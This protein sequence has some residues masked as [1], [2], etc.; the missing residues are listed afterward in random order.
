MLKRFFRK[1]ETRAYDQYWSQF[2][3]IRSGTAVT[4]DSAQS[5]SACYSAV[6]VIS[7]AIGALPLHLYKR[8]GDDQTKA[9]GH[10]LYG[11][12]HHEPNDQQSACEFREWL[13]AS[14]LLTGNGYAR[15]ER[16]HDGQVRSLSPL[17][18]DRVNVVIKAGRIAGYEFH[19]DDGVQHKLLPDEVFHLRHRAGDNPLIGV[20]PITASRQTFEVA[21]AEREHGHSSFANGTRLSGVLKYPQVLKQEQRDALKASWN[22]QY[23]GG[24]NAGRVALLEAGV[25]FQ[26]LSMSLADAD[27]VAIRKFSVEEV[28]R[29]FKIPSVLIGDMSQSTYNNV[30]LLMRWFVQHT[31]KRHLVAWEGAITRQLLTPA[32]R[33]IYQPKFSVEGLLRGD[34]ITRAQ[35]YERALA[36]GW[37]TIGEV[38]K[39]EDLPALP[40]TPKP[41]EAQA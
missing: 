1:T 25:D 22:S 33:R 37:M 18:P 39:L 6:S 4:P 36:D 29:L 15:I 11:V 9:V 38:R 17:R 12:L 35:F 23:A 10:S 40:Q 14:M 8:E 5:I 26:A 7:E 41:W 13:T 31:L 27:Y 21:L 24:A 34:S 28:A 20:S 19:D 30:D 3:A 16:G 2:A 32:G